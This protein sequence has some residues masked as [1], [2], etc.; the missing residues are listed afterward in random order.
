MDRFVK[1]STLLLD[2]SSYKN[3]LNEKGTYV[4]LPDIE[5]QS[6]AQMEKIL[7]T[8]V[9]QFLHTWVYAKEEDWFKIVKECKFDVSESQEQVN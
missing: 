4:V 7:N 2:D 1:Y 8:D 6:K 3:H 9:L 5:K